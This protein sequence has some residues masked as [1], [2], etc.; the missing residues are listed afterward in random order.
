MSRFLVFKHSKS[1]AAH[2]GPLLLERAYNEHGPVLRLASLHAKPA[3]EMGEKIEKLRALVER[4]TIQGVVVSERTLRD[5]TEELDTPK[6]RIGRLV[7]E[8]K[9]A[10]AVRLEPRKGKGGGEMLIANSRAEPRPDWRAEA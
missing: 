10:Q 7:T 5:Y 2:A 6:G 4:L 1:N 9:V 8:A 3:A